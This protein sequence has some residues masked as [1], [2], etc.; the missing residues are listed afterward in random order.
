MTFFIHGFEYIV[1]KCVKKMSDQ[2][3]FAEVNSFW[4]LIAKVSSYH[5]TCASFCESSLSRLNLL[6]IVPSY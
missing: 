5:P 6:S 1:G 4:E 2:D 3:N